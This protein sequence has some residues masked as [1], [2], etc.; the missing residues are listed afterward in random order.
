MALF[1]T[2]DGILMLGTY[3]WAYINPV[4]KIYYNL[5]ITFFSIVVAFVI[6]GIELLNII[7]EQVRVGGT[8]LGFFAM[9][10]DNFNLIG[11]LIIVLF[12]GTFFIAKI[13]Y[14][15]LGSEELEH[16][17]DEQEGNNIVGANNEK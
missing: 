9:L 5:V 2:A 15:A 6:G 12:V 11:Y 16:K 14:K 1:D 7:G 17:F 13:F 3:T 4:R 8:F 10:G